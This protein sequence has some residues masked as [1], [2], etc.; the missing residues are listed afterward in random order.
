MLTFVIGLV[1]IIIVSI[2]ILFIH[3]YLTHDGKLYD[4]ED[5]KSAI[6]GLF[7][8]HEGIIVLLLIVAIGVII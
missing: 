8:S 1:G 5:F 2:I 4:P 7:S 6:R 3:H